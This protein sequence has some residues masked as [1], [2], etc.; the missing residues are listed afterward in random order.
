M[1]TDILKIGAHPLSGNPSKAME[2][3]FSRAF[4]WVASGSQEPDAVAS[5]DE[6]YSRTMKSVYGENWTWKEAAET[7]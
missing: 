1:W 3:I 2:M 5:S 4:P 6:I 7:Q